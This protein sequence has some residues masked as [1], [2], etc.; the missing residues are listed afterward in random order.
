MSYDSWKTTDPRDSEPDY[1]VPTNDRDEVDD[2][3]RADMEYL[4]PDNG[5]TSCYAVTV[6]VTVPSRVTLDAVR[7][8]IQSNIESVNG[9]SVD[10]I[11]PVTSAL[12]ASAAWILVHRMFVDIVTN[13]PSTRP[14]G[15]NLAVSKVAAIVCD[16][17]DADRE[18]FGPLHT[19]YAEVKALWL[20]R[21]DSAV[22][23]G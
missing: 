13:W 4:D 5:W 11:E 19:A 18:T 22:K 9:W 7:A 17:V 6:E 3:E 2:S 1:D 8:E 12:S 23:R 20:R 15:S 16:V 14:D 21:W 10:R